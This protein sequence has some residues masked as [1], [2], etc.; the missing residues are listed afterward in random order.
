MK[1]KSPILLVVAALLFFGTMLADAQADFVFVKTLRKGSSGT[2]IR[3][4]QEV[5]AA[6]PDI[7]PEKLITGYFGVLTRQA[8][9]RFQSKYGI[10][11]S[12]DENT[13]GYG[14]VGPKTRKKLNEFMAG[15]QA[16]LPQATATPSSSERK[17]NPALCPDNIWDEAEQKDANLCPEDNP[18]NNP[19]SVVA[20]P[21]AGGSLQASS[22]PSVSTTT[23]TQ[24]GPAP[25]P[26]QTPAILF[27][28]AKDS[29]VRVSGG[30]VPYVYKLKDGR[31]RIYYCG[32]R[33]SIES[34][35]SSDGLNFQ[36]E[37]GTRLMPMY[38]GF[39]T[40]ICDPTLVE[41]SDG[42]FR[43]YYK[44]TNTGGVSQ[45]SIHKIFAAVS[46]DGLN[47]E[48]E[49]IVIDSEKT[50]D[51]GWA[52][53]PDAIK[54]SDGRIRL[55]YVS[56]A[57]GRG[58]IVS[59]IS[60]DGLNFTKEQTKIYDYVDPSVTQ[61]EDGRFFLV[62]ANFTPQGGTELYGFISN[63]GTHFDN[64]NP[65]SVIVESVADPAIVMVNDKIYRIYYWKI[66]DSS[67]VVYSITGTITGQ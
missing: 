9:Q 14:Q 31:F 5:L 46:S 33:G 58:C 17:T 25:T 45:T 19:K 2:E 62:T 47:F 48:R 26:S 36:T 10:V 1:Y 35:I 61:L 32:L 49:G 8:V 38:G 40:I 29:G 18:T 3:K 63:D 13:T 4:L 42:R 59:A 39:E 54:L 15:P 23:P 57:C 51:Q 22:S 64:A 52:S 24:I 50:D 21:P 30:Q 41:L 27:T 55:Y 43:L 34:A 11:S 37:S 66:P 16:G 60:S 56:R 44:G 20:N 12:G 28:W 53:V 65:Q 6:M 7:Y 67:P